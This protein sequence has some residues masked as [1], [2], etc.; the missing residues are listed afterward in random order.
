M[1]IAQPNILQVM[2]NQL[3]HAIHSKNPSINRYSLLLTKMD[4]LGTRRAEIPKKIQEKMAAI[5][6]IENDVLRSKL[7]GA[8]FWSIFFGKLP[9]LVCLIEILT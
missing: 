9:K 5:S 4:F 3:I 1:T 2:N 7:H 6:Q 8:Y